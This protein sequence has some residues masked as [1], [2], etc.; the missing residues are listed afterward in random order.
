MD[1]MCALGY[2]NVID[3]YWMIWLCVYDVEWQI[4]E[5]WILYW[6]AVE[7]SFVYRCARKF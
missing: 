5:M 3:K 6:Y 1:N 7:M 4:N 2:Y